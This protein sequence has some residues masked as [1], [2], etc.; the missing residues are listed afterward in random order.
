VVQGCGVLEKSLLYSA[1]FPVF[2]EDINYPLSICYLLTASACYFISMVYI[3]R[4]FG[5][6]LRKTYSSVKDDTMT[7]VEMVFMGFDWSVHE[8]S[9]VHVNKRVAL[10]SLRCLVHQMKKE[11][12]ESEMK[13][14]QIFWRFIVRTFISA[15]FYGIIT[16]SWYGV[17]TITLLQQQIEDQL[18]EFGEFNNDI[19]NQLELGV[20]FWITLIQFLISGTLFLMNKLSGP[21]FTFLGRFEKFSDEVAMKCLTV[22]LI[23]FQF[24]SIAVLVYTELSN[25]NK[26]L[27]PTDHV[28]WEAE[29]GK[30]IYSLLMFQLFIWIVKLISD[31]VIFLPMRLI[32]LKFFQDLVLSELDVTDSALELL[33]LQSLS[34]IG[35]VIAPLIP[36]ITLLLLLFYHLLLYLKLLLF[37][38]PSCKLRAPDATKYMF[39][40]GSG[41][42]YVCALGCTTLMLLML[43]PSFGCS[44]FKGLQTPLRSV[45]Y[46]VCGIAGEY[47][48]WLK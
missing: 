6:Y 39:V 36:A 33:N 27:C 1:N 38:K 30:Q 18:N 25:P 31:I 22:R 28:C 2:L 8:K 3:V 24:S 21:L 16:M 14:R 40:I 17:Y 13:R 29:V 11:E 20:A 23:L 34:W 43:R 10:I 41:V 4:R 7:I 12:K 35:V 48:M 45:L 32:P 46:Y 9:A 5:T 44:F 15:L 19:L 47:W 37:C 42:S 26:D